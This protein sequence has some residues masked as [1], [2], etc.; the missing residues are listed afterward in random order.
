MSTVV[1][2]SQRKVIRS[3]N[4]LLCVVYLTSIVSFYLFLSHQQDNLV[5]HVK[6]HLI[7]TIELD[8]IDIKPLT[9]WLTLTGEIALKE[10]GS[11]EKKWHKRYV[12]VANSP[13]I[14]ELTYPLWS[15][16][17]SIYFWI[18]SIVFLWGAR[19]SNVLVR[20]GLIAS[21]ADYQSLENWA[22]LAIIQG[23][24]KPLA[25]DNNISLVITQ[26]QKQIQDGT[27]KGFTYDHSIRESLLLDAD[28]G[29]GNRAFFDNR[30]NAFLKEDDV[31]GAVL[32]VDFKECEL[33][34]SLYGHQ[35][36]INLLVTLIQVIKHRLQRLPSFF[37]AR[38]GEF[39][40]A[41]LLPGIFMNETEKLAD[42]LITNI[43]AVNIP[44]GVNQEEFVH[45]G[46]SYFGHD[47]S[48]YQIMAEADM[49]MRSA[50]LQGPSQWFMY[51]VGELEHVKAKGSLRWRTFLTHALASN[52]FVIFFQPVIDSQSE[53]VIHHE[54]LSK[55]RDKDGSLISARV[56]LPMAQKCGLAD[57]IDLLILEQVCRVLAYEDKQRDDCSLNISIDSLLSPTFIDQFI[58][59]INR[60]P[61]VSERIIIEI[62]EYQLVNHLN[63][64]VP[65]L[66]RINNSGVKILAD[67]V[68]Q[69]IV[70]AGYL[71]I[72]PISAIKLHRSIVIDIDKKN[73]NQVFIQSLKNL[74]EPQQ[75]P[76]YALGVE[77]I[78]EWRML[79]KLGIHGG[80]GHFFTEPVAQVAKAIHLL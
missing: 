71:K 50:Q 69:F 7:E 80:Q 1:Q 53:N 64:L 47:Q 15:I 61:E 40:L 49:A 5:N 66:K 28:T 73:E 75:I 48:A 55:V 29:I 37:L 45:M 3:I 39:E 8:K 65:V 26:L 27:N 2:Q 70:S 6:S 77:N 12:T 20:Q 19:Y 22:N 72:C 68:G 67:K 43:Q 11:S 35:Q 4:L 9:S 34:Q 62:S 25:G 41:I 21:R 23:Q 10:Q 14:I 52:A 57:K 51:E 54:V 32:F 33:I 58:E 78:A 74:T 76:I 79:V 56:F 36:A 59:I 24:A 46:I 30:L 18:F 60:Y 42:R 17:A 44:I 31:Q 63:D 16:V 13:W 38:R